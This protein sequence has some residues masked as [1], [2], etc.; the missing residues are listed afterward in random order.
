MRRVLLIVAA[1]LLGACDSSE[2]SSGTPCAMP[3]DGFCVC[4]E[5]APPVGSVREC[6][7][8]TMGGAVVCC[9]GKDDCSCGRFDC[10]TPSGNFCSCTSVGVGDKVATCSGMICC[11]AAGGTCS[12]GTSA[13]SDAETQVSSCTA[14]TARCSNGE[15]RVAKCG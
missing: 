4:G 6:S 3:I 5:D 15:T 7:A 11:A 8:A 2:S 9:Q 13:C 14:A 1:A 10:S 12:C